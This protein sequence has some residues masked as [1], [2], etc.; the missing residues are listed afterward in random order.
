MK[1]FRVFVP[2]SF[3]LCSVLL[4]VSCT[5]VKESVDFSTMTSEEIMD[6][7]L[8]HGA[9]PFSEFIKPFK[10][11][12]SGE[13]PYS[14]GSLRDAKLETVK[15]YDE[16]IKISGDK[17]QKVIVNGDIDLPPGVY[18][19]TVYYATK[20]VKCQPKEVYTIADSPM[21]GFDPTEG[22]ASKHRG[23]AG[24]MSAGYWKMKTLIYKIEF[25]VLGQPTNRPYSPC[26]PNAVQW[27]YYRGTL[28]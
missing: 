27:Q 8:K 13:A 23:Y 21:C 24:V 16:L 17:P 12:T 9:I 15:G 19:A 7:G 25:N 5:Q 20:K 28:N 4:L 1:T 11:P 18:F 3:L 26:T 6:Y 10:I 2:F 14:I 22:G